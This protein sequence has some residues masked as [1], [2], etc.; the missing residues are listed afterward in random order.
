[1]VGSSYSIG[2]LHAPR[3]VL[4]GA[5]RATTEG[6]D[7][8]SLQRG[9]RR[10]AVPKVSELGQTIESRK[11]E[12]RKRRAKESGWSTSMERLWWRHRPPE[13]LRKRI[14][15]AIA[16]GRDTLRPV[17]QNGNRV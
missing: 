2:A 5:G 7:L 9:A 4:P 8:H 16:T 17:F 3:Q 13:P 14:F 15:A 1:M 6:D 10:L 12:S 11:V